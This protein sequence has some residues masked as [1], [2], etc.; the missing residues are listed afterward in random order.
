MAAK[1]YRTMPL[2]DKTVL[3]TGASS[4]IGEATA[5]RLAAEGCRRFVLLARR[6]ERLEALAEALRAEVGA[7]CHVVQCDVA[8]EATRLAT[9][10]FDELPEAFRQ[11]HICV[12]NAGL[13]L[14]KDPADAV[15][16]D[17]VQ[18]VITV[19]VTATIALAST[20]LKRAR[21]AGAGHLVLVGSVAGHDAYPGG[22]V[23]C[24]SKAAIVS[25]A[26]AARGDLVSTPVRVSL[27]SPGAVNTCGAAPQPRLLPWRSLSPAAATLPTP[28]PVT[29]ASFL[30][31]G[32][33]ATR[34][35]QTRYTRASYLSWPMMSPTRS[36]MP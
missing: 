1:P 24:A 12:A 2:D 14:G 28:L 30:S 9:S 27:I 21:A 26:A 23:Y 6:I 20:F 15:A 31:C 18:R 3:I 22:S 36:G 19:N 33:A 13:A 10:L 29:A 34:P 35:R 7:E 5:R 11:V 32:S 4:G 16:L 17:D 8:Q 25:F